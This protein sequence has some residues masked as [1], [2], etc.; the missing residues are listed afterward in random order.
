MSDW[1]YIYINILKKIKTMN[2][3]SRNLILNEYKQILDELSKKFINSYPRRSFKTILRK[4]PEYR[5]R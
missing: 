5:K 1:E 4:P 2:L 3:K